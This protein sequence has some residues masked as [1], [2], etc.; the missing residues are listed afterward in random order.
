MLVQE[1]VQCVV[2]LCNVIESGRVR[3]LDYT[4]GKIVNCSK[5]AEAIDISEVEIKDEEGKAYKYRH[6]HFWSWPDHGVPENLE[7]LNWVIN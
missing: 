1:K 5:R 3:C 7:H 4:D 6:V 2:M